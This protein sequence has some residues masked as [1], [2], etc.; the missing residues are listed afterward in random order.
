MKIASD[1]SEVAMMMVTTP[2]GLASLSVMFHVLG[3]SAFIFYSEKMKYKPNSIAWFMFAYGTTVTAVLEKE[4]GAPLPLLLLPGICAMFS[5]W[6]AFRCLFN[7]NAKLP[8]HPLD[9]AALLTDITITVCYLLVSHAMKTGMVS[10]EFR[11]HVVLGLLI[12]STLGTFL[13]YIPQIRGMLRGDATEHWLPWTLWGIAYVFLAATTLRMYGPGTVLMLYPLINLGL[14][15]VISFIAA[16]LSRNT[17]RK[18]VE[19]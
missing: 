18:S 15:I 13:P 8:E 19:Q 5:I 16:F 7:G 2:D 3:Y 11:E 10:G 17:Q 4:V 12:A 9:W 14:C 1:L 6:I